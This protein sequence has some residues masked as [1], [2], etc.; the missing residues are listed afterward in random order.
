MDENDNDDGVSITYGKPLPATFQV[1]DGR[2][3][4]G[5]VLLNRGDYYASKAVLVDDTPFSVP[6]GSDLKGICRAKKMSLLDCRGCELSRGLVPTATP[7]EFVSEC[8]ITFRYATFGDHHLSRDDRVIRGIRFTF[9]HADAMFTNLGYDAFGSLL[10]PNREVLDAIKRQVETDEYSRNQ[11][12][13]FRYDGSAMVYYFTGKGTL[14]PNTDTVLGTISA[15]RRWG[16]HWRNANE[17]TPFLAIEVDH[18][19]PMTL[20]EAFEK[21]RVVRQFLTWM[22]GFAPRWDG[23]FV[24][25]DLEGDKRQHNVY[26][27]I[28]WDEAQDNE[29]LARRRNMLVDPSREPDKFSAVLAEWLKRNACDERGVANTTFFE[30]MPGRFSHLPQHVL[31]QAADALDMLPPRDKPGL[32]P[33]P[34]PIRELLR[35]THISIREM[36]EFQSDPARKRVLDG[37]GR[38]NS[39][40]NLRDTVEH[41]ADIILDHLNENKMP[42]LKELG[43]MA[44]RCRN[45]FTHNQTAPGH[46][47]FTNNYTVSLLAQTLQFI[48]GASELVKCGWD[49]NAWLPTGFAQFH[50]FGV[51]VK[52]NYGIAV[53]RALP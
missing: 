27:P 5:Y 20:E 12:D 51:Y 18:N 13:D 44:V 17:N 36:S 31:R 11:P 50:A 14:F 7:D 34:E 4:S 38:L 2:E 46:V 30:S 32:P 25:T 29:I 19:S 6:E 43:Y 42:R 3:V 33:I 37:L 53:H 22:T 35:K 8:E 48:Y 9:D 24:F 16:M 40:V 41:R 28:E 47:D 49:M 15:S 23:V 39:Y 52:H 45:Y 10:D 1:D 26:S 21:M